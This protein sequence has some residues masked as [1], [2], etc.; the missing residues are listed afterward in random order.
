MAQQ[1]G[2]AREGGDRRQ[3]EEGDTR[4]VQAK[5]VHLLNVVGV[6]GGVT[7]DV[8]RQRADL[9]LLHGLKKCGQSQKG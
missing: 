9:P 6:V 4:R 5:R 3:N 7:V 1:H 8:I 2:Q